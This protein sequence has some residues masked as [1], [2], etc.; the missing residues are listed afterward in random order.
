MPP[1]KTVLILLLL[2]AIS[3]PVFAADVSGKWTGQMVIGMD[4]K[5]IPFVMDLKLDGSTL[6]GTFC[7]R[8][9]TGNKQPMQNAKI[10]GDAISFS[11]VTDTLDVPQFDF[12]G[13]ISGDE[14]KFI[15][16]G[17]AEQCGGASCQI[18][19]ASATRAK[20]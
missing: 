17:K 19:T 11:V 12:Q 5:T 1:L 9:C 3:T 14:I 2:A 20:Q 7:F 18:G 16:T 4:A 8:D 10:A 15:I 13:T 6:A